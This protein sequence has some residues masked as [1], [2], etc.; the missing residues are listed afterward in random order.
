MPVSEPPRAVGAVGRPAPWEARAF[1]LFRVALGGAALRTGVDL[2]VDLP[3]VLA[4]GVLRLPYA[5]RLPDPPPGAVRPLLALWTLAAVA[6]AVG[7][8]SRLAGALLCVLAG[9]LLFLD[10]QLYGNHFYLLWLLL[11]LATAGNA[12]AAVSLDAR[13]GRGG[14]VV[15]WA[16]TLA[17]V[18]LSLVYGSGALA[19]VN[20][21]YLAGSLVGGPVGH[22]GAWLGVVPGETALRS[23]AIASIA[24]ELTLAAAV[25]S[26]RLWPACVALGATFHVGILA[27]LGPN[28]GLAVFAVETLALYLL[29]PGAQRFLG[30]QDGIAGRAARR[31]PA[32]IQAPRAIAVSAVAAAPAHSERG[33]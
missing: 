3:E 23:A 26:R 6:L 11:V 17:R 30:G 19:K 13:R 25:W 24:L 18:Q 14:Q 8:R 10:Q 12:G 20:A 7:W 33:T 27:G 16:V 4:S 29:F 2:L 32:T 5:V 31:R 21:S 28:L 22:A 15:P 9:W 1:G